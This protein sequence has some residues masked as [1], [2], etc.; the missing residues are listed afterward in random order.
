MLAVAEAGAIDETLQ[1]WLTPSI[2]SSIRPVWRTRPGS[3]PE[4][5]DDAYIADYRLADDLKADADAARA[6]LA[7]LDLLDVRAARREYAKAVGRLK[8]L[9]ISR[10]TTAEDLALQIDTL[11][12]ELIEYP[13][14]IV[15]AAYKAWARGQRFFPAWAELRA[16]CEDGV[17]WRRGLAHAL[18][19]YIELAERR[20]TET[21]ALPPK[22][23][24]AVVVWRA[25]EADLK[26]AFEAREWRAWISRSIPHRDDGETLRLAVPT[27]FIMDWINANYAAKLGAIIG[28]RVVCEVHTWAGAALD[29]RDRRAATKSAQEADGDAA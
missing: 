12:T 3:D 5:W 18:R 8:T 19:A 9:T 4:I 10:A 27:R 16:L 26:G 11:A 1:A 14:D 6:A 22:D 29:E 23:P 13:I 7:L 24:P 25:H 2:A 15:N 17:C 20:E 21:K 28:R